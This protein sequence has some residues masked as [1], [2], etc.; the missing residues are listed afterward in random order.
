[1]VVVIG[2]CPVDGLLRA[3]SVL[4]IRVGNGVCTIDRACKLSAVPRHRVTAVGRRIAACIVTN[5]FPIVGRQLVCPSLIFGFVPIG[6]GIRSRTKR[7]SVRN[8]G[9]LG[10][11]Q[12]VATIIVGVRDRFS[13][14]EC[15]GDRA[16]ILREIIDRMQFL[17]YKPV[18]FP[19]RIGKILRKFT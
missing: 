12:N 13:A 15:F 5:R 18:P 6:N 2:C 8:V 10:L 1:M 16:V 19:V 11:I 17:N 14:C 9:I 7:A 4:V 3:D